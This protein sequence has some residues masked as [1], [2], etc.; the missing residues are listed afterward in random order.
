MVG[1]VLTDT[2]AETFLRQWEYALCNFAPDTI[3]I[4]GGAGHEGIVWDT[5]VVIAGPD[6]L[7]VDHDLVLLAPENGLNL[8]GETSLAD[9]VHPTN[10][11]YWFG[12]DS[13]HIEAE[14]FDE[15]APDAKVFVP[16]DSSD[17]MYSWAAWVVTAWDRRCKA[18]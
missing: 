8:Q 17:Q 13:A 9:F 18:A 11:V 15:R 7:P 5:A 1:V 10:C 16:T 2:S 6:E 4:H 3:Y 14:V 12:S